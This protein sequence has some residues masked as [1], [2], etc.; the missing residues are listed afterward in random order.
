MEREASN[1]GRASSTL[2]RDI[3]HLGWMLS[4]YLKV[5]PV[6]GPLLLLLQ[7]AAGAVIVVSQLQVQRN[8]AVIA[9]ALAAKT[10]AAIPGPMSIIMG[11]ILTIAGLGIVTVFVQ[12]ALRMRFRRVITGGMLDRWI[13]ENRFLHLEQR[14]GADYPEQRIQ[15]DVFQTIDRTMMRG[16]EVIMGLF[17]VFIYTGQLWKV[18]PPLTIPALGIHQPIHGYLVYVAFGLA[19]SMTFLTHWVGVRLTRA[20]IDRQTLEAR[21]RQ[22]LA[23]IRLNGETVAFTRAAGIERTRLAETFDIIRRNWRAYTNA[24][25]AIG[26]VTGVPTSLLL[27]APTLLCAPFILNGTMKI[28]DV[29]L[30]AASLSGT[31]VGAGILMANYAEL[32]LLRSAVAR[33][34]VFHER[35]NQENRSELDVAQEARVDVRTQGLRIAFPDGHLMNEV[36]DLT[37]AKGDRLLIQGRSGAGKSTLLRAIAG[38]WPFGGGQVRLPKDAKIAFLPQRPYM[39]DGTLAGLM[40][41]PDPPDAHAD[42]AYI[43]LLGQLGLERLTDRLHEFAP[44]SRTL[45]PGEQQRIAAARAILAAPDFLFVD[46]ATSALD[47]ELEASLYGLL[48]EHLPGAALISVAHRPTV[49]RFHDTAIRL[50]DGRTRRIKLD[51]ADGLAGA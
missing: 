36:G 22:Q 20:E 34:R 48:A 5:D 31:Y 49:A 51:P 39:P 27:I 6:V 30:V 24:R 21:Y 19:I 10:G 12:Y 41:Y 26:V 40:A 37:I 7:L 4:R 33:L 16:P 43:D 2:G 9:N 32:A 17:T 45:S 15:E 50:E 46:E 44:W 42:A 3:A 38:L 14:G 35:L 8:L 18:S 11:L 29:T 23:A 13:G 47:P 28:G 1:N 25:L